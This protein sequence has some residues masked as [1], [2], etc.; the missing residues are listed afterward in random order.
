MDYRRGAA[1]RS[2]STPLKRHRGRSCVWWFLFGALLG[3]AGTSLYWT[4]QPLSPEQAEPSEARTQRPMPVQPSF[5]FPQLLRDTEVEIDTGE[6]PPATPQAPAPGTPNAPQPG[7]PATPAAATPPATAPPTAQPAAPSAAVPAASAPA[8][9]GSFV[10]QIGSFKS[11]ADAER[12][13]AELG[14]LGVSSHIQTVT[15][16]SGEVYHR[17]RT[18]PYGSKREADEA[19]TRLKGS[20]KDGLTLP[21]N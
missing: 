15:L 4:R 7:A 19:R 18:G 17:V 12:L 1:S 10:V 8:A 9:G 20:G 3:A 14:L 21:L 16:A 5:Q 2:S 13:R 6:L 11:V